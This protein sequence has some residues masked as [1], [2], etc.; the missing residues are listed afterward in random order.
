MVTLFYCFIAHTYSYYKQESRQDRSP[1]HSAYLLL[2]RSDSSSTWAISLFFLSTVVSLIRTLMILYLG[3]FFFT[4]NFLDYIL[5]LLFS[6]FLP[7]LFL[8][9]IPYLSSPFNAVLGVSIQFVQSSKPCLG[10]FFDLLTLPQH[11]ISFHRIILNLI[12]TILRK[13]CFLHVNSMYS[14]NQ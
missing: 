3:Y 2:Y 6:F 5:L 13:Q 4:L 9:L 10:S 12:G 1:A 14:L 8:Y 7:T 11:Q